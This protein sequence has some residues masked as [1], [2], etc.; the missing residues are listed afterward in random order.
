MPGRDDFA[1]IRAR[2]FADD[3]AHQAATLYVESGIALEATALAAVVGHIAEIGVWAS[4]ETD[5][6]VLPGDGIGVVSVA[7]MS[8]RSV[9]VIVVRVLT[10]CALMRVHGQGLYVCGF[11]DCYS[12]IYKKRERD[13]EYA[14]QARYQR[15]DRVSRRRRR[16]VGA[17]SGR[18]R[19]DVG[20]ESDCTA[21]A[22]AA[23]AE[24]ESPPSAAGDSASPPPDTASANGHDRPLTECESQLA[25]IVIDCLARHQGCDDAEQRFGFEMR[26]ALRQGL[27]EPKD[28]RDMIAKYSPRK[29]IRESVGVALN[30]KRAIDS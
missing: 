3:R 7:T 24:S 18:S 17:T 14:S 28:V 25:G 23:A 15:K 2:L 6:G 1:I 27:A 8:P 9:A 29:G 16:D 20:T 10:Q 30:V 5:D 21:A 12:A 13:R 19:D 11:A 26:K 22:A 4:R